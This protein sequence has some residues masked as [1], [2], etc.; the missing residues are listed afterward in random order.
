MV[1]TFILILECSERFNA[2]Q[3]ISIVY[4]L[5]ISYLRV[6]IDPFERFVEQSSGFV[7]NIEVFV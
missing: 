2:M 6:F 4:T 7:Y 3:V 1:N 5:T